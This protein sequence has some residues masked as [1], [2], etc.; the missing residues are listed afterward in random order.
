M[1]KLS[2]IVAMSEN[3]V[4]GVDNH[5]PW[6]IPEDLKRFKKITLGHP[7]VMGRKTY[8]S[9]GRVLPG[10]TN[11]VV[12][13]ERAYRVEGGAVCH[14][15]EEALEWARRAPGSEEV[16]VIGG[17]ELFRQAL[18]LASRIYLTE[19]HWPFEGDTFFPPFPEDD[20]KETSREILSENP[21]A[22]LRVLERKRPELAWE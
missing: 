6:N 12:T 5:L 9:I 10:R 21:A 2:L 4:I 11:V 20:Y 7:I 22:L 16:F 14:S 15:F 8:E 18:P 1:A 19:V 3:R 13:R 17:A